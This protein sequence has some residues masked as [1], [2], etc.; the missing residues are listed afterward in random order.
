MCPNLFPDQLPC[1][2]TVC[3]QID[4]KAT[5]ILAVD[6]QNTLTIQKGTLPLHFYRTLAQLFSIKDSIEPWIRQVHVTVV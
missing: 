5:N 1:M 3:L 4:D 6:N 2:S